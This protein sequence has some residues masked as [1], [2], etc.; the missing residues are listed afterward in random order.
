LEEKMRKVKVQIAKLGNLNA[1]LDLSRVTKWSSDLFE[2]LPGIDQHSLPARA[3]GFLWDF[4]D[5]QLSRSV[6]RRVEG[7]FLLVLTDCPLEGNYYMRRLSGNR[8]CITFYQ[9]KDI[10]ASEDIPL[11]SFVLK[12]IY[13]ALILYTLAANNGGDLPESEESYTHDETKGCLFDMTGNKA[14]LVVSCRGPSLCDT[15]MADFSR[16]SVPKNLLE[17]VCRELRRIRKP[18]YLRLT[19]T[20]KRHPILS[21]LITGAT[22]IILNVISNLITKLFE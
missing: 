17:T 22:A 2:V 21:L 10:L 3:E 12:C 5:R 7:D 11:E 14:D 9:V 4:T 19:T 1:W 13:E 8:V 18:T 6:P 16:K 20:I 15:C